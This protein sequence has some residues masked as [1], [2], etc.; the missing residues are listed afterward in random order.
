M[1]ANGF[2]RYIIAAANLAEAE[3]IAQDNGL[4]RREWTYAYCGY[5][6]RQLK[7][8]LRVDS[9][10]RL[11]GDFKPEERWLLTAHLDKGRTQDV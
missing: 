1:N 7:D 9:E 11:L 3:Q 5:P 4:R 6:T 10:D 2:Q 8:G